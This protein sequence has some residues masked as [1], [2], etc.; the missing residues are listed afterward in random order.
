MYYYIPTIHRRY[1]HVLHPTGHA[2][3]LVQSDKKDVDHFDPNYFSGGENWQ[4]PDLF[5]SEVWYG[6]TRKIYEAFG[7]KVFNSTE[8]GMLEVFERTSL[9]DFLE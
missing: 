8:G 9:E 2:N 3:K 5:E 6:R 1:A 7:R 4:L